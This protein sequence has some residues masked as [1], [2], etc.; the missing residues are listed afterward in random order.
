MTQRVRFI[1][2]IRES[3]HQQVDQSIDS[4]Y[5]P[6]FEKSKSLIASIKVSLDRLQNQIK[7]DE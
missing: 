4:L 3:L 7:K 6:Y 1:E 2:K 5:L